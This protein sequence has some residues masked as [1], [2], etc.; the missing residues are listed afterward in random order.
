[1]GRLDLSDRRV[2]WVNVTREF[3][4]ELYDEVAALRAENLTLVMQ[5]DALVGERELA[6]LREAA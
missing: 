2:D 1:M 6:R 5:L 4:D 3:L